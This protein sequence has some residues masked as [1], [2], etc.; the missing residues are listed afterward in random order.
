[1]NI[2][3]KLRKT[4]IITG[5]S[6]GLGRALTIEYA[7][8]GWRIYICGRNSQRL[9]D[10]VS[11]A[12][13]YTCEI[14]SKI[15]DVTNTEDV[16]EWIETIAL[17]YKIDLVI[18]NA[19]VS[20]GTLQNRQ[21]GARQV[22]EI[23]NINFNGVINS[24]YPLI[25]ILQKQKYGQIAVVSSIA[26][27]FPLPGA[28]AYSSSKAAIRYFADALR[29]ELKADN[30][31]VCT[32]FPGFIDTPMTLMNNFPMPFTIS[33]IKAAQI[34]KHGL[35]KNKTYI[36]FPKL[37]YF[38]LKLLSLM[39]RLILDFILAKISRDSNFKEQIK[40]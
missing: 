34:I 13:V 22:N 2:Y 37:F 1:M 38:G 5:A 24:I 11:A 15:L 25:P 10:T 19:G 23:M 18:A 26:S 14:Y 28:S 3:K 27:F 32:I 21:G 20:A 6:S 4:I 7:K 30:I 29:I 31:K 8:A 12:L 36:G 33:S 16:A 39:P 40:Q 9:K 35:D 17:A